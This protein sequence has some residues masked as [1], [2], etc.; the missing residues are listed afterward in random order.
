MADRLFNHVGFQEYLKEHKVMGCRNK[1]SGKLYLPP[2]AMCPESH[3]TD[4]EWVEIS[5]KGKLIGFTVITVG[6][7]FMI[8]DGYN[9]DNPFCAG[10]VQL[11]EGPAISAQIFGVDVKNP[12]NIKIGTEVQATFIERGQE[13]DRRTYLGFEAV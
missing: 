3:T 10:I 5:G 6:P 2:R 9:R 8:E 7:T 13:P 4:M 12:E 11:D 1:T